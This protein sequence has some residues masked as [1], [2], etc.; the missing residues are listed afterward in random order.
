MFSVD[1]LVQ[2]PA[3]AAESP[4]GSRGDLPI[5]HLVGSGVAKD[6]AVK[7]FIE[8]LAAAVWRGHGA[9]GAGA[10]GVWQAVEQAALGF[11]AL[12]EANLA[13]EVAPPTANG[14]PESILPN[15]SAPSA[16]EGRRIAADQSLETR[17]Q[18]DK[19]D[20]G[21]AAVLVG[22]SRDLIVAAD[23]PQANPMDPALAPMSGLAGPI[24]ASGEGV[25]ATP[26]RPAGLA[27]STRT[28]GVLGV[29]VP[30]LDDDPP[31]APP[32]SDSERDL[33]VT[34]AGASG[35][36]DLVAGGV[37]RLVVSGRGEL[38]L[39]NAGAVHSIDFVNHATADINLFYDATSPSAPASQ[40][41]RLGGAT[42]VS[43]AEAAAPEAQPVRLV[44]NSQ[45]GQSNDL[46]ILDPA[47]GQA[48]D[49]S[50]KIIGEESLTLHESAATF[51]ASRLD[52][53][54]LTGTLTIGIDLTD[55]AAGATVLNFGS[56]N[57]IVNPQDSVALENLGDDA[58]IRIDVDLNSA[59]FGFGGRASST[60]GSLALALDLGAAGQNAPVS[61]GLIDATG[62]DNLSI[63][64][65]GGDN[66]AQ[67]IIDPALTNL[68]LTG[69]GALEIDAIAG[70]KAI[71]GQSVDID[72]SGLAGFLTLNAGGISDAAAGGRAV[73]IALGPGGGAVTDMNASEAVT[74]TLGVGQGRLYFAD[75]ATLVTIAGLKSTD[76]VSVGD[77]KVADTFVN[78]FATSPS[79]QTS[80]DASAN[81]LVAATTAATVAGAVAA[82]QAVLFSYK[83]DSY[84]F[85]DVV[86][87]HVFDPSLDAI[88]KLVGVLPTT[89]F[90][91]VF[92]SA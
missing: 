61:I 29:L 13:T 67:T 17:A 89:D 60:T 30:A 11:A 57:F 42:H 48:A 35:T 55:G 74:V 4:R 32:I 77:A 19:P 24:G 12:Y 9:E 86:G 63:T 47:P 90:A 34:L 8:A 28:A 6:G 78:G 36:L 72:A 38:A 76:Q 37:W 71:D 40:T 7:A 82:H 31:D 26:W 52:A 53:S 46:N 68:Q 15:V 43:L 18:I 91:G 14:E 85:V 21:R 41:L 84:V 20:D 27:S 83:G 51:S 81:L 80:I 88:I 33:A 64:S 65:S 58:T 62:V 45:G 56:G 69:D 1:A 75:G 2:H 49:F 22:S 54:K 39:I 70:V 92:H 50:L 3:H 73:S 23:A 44:V 25:G 59:I 10:G 66:V 79:Q 16:E 5:D 87:N